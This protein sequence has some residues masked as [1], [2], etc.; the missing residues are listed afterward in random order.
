YEDANGALNNYR[1]EGNVVAIP[2]TWSSFR[3]TESFSNAFGGEWDFTDKLKVSGE[4]S[5]AESD[6]SLPNSEFNW[7]AIDPVLEAADPSK[8]NEWYSD[9]TINNSQSKA[10]GVV[11]DDG[12]IYTQSE[13]FALREY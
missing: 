5:S 13:H 9:V 4:Y 10:P 1:M 12:E 7:R 8:A 11:Y 2:K 3:S 6:S